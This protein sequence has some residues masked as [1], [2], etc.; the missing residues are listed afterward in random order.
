MR[1]KVIALAMIAVMVVSLTACGGKNNDKQGKDSTE[2]LKVAYQSGIAYAPILVMK[3]Q[4]LI[5]KNYDGNVDIDWQ[6]L[7][8]GAAISEGLTSNTVDVG[9]IGTGVAITGAKAGAPY[10]IFAGMSSQPY[11][12]STNKEEIKTLKDITK[13]DQIAITGI[14]SQPHI[15]LAMAAKAYLGDAH[16]LDANLVA[17]PNA[18]GYTSLVSGA[19]QC[20]MIMSPYCFMEQNKEGI[21]Q[22]EVDESVWPVGD[23]TI[24]GVAT[25]KLKEERPKLYEAVCKAMDEAIEFI[26]DNP[27]KTADILKDYYDASQEEIVSWLTNDASVFSAKLQGVMKLSDFMVEEDFLDKGPESISEIAFDNVEG[28]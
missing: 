4:K 7:S 10:K 19:V 6:L 24:V 1:K 12:I 13:E 23:T 2:S 25:D 20:H 11:R 26:N 16:A 18:D 3:D 22:I 5:E 17:Q 21:H 14:N 27:E 28:N 8:G 9:A 15:V